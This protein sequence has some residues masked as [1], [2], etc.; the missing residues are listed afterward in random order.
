MVWDQGR[1]GEA[2]GLY[3]EAMKIDVDT[4]GT[5]HPNYAARLSNLGVNMAYQK[6]YTEARDLLEQAL[7][8]QKVVLPADHPDIAFDRRQHRRCHCRHAIAP[9]AC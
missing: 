6:K 8:I 1:Y 2:E 4:I 5:A 9:L 7:V 3:R